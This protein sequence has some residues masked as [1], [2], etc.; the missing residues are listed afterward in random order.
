MAQELIQQWRLAV[1]RVQLD[2]SSAVPAVI[3]ELLTYAGREPRQL[4][5]SRHPI[6]AFGPID[7]AGP[8]H[9]LRVP[10]DLRD[11][12]AESLHTDLRGE[13]SLW[14]R[15]V[16]PYGY[17]GAVPWEQSLLDIV[18]VP[19]FRVPERLPVAT[20]P[21]RRWTVAIGVNA[22][23]DTD[24]A[25]GYVADLVASLEVNAGPDVEVDVF[26]DAGTVASLRARS[27]D[28]PAWAHL[29]EPGQAR[30]ASH[31]RVRRL[32]S[33]SSRVPDTPP[34]IDFT[35]PGRIWADW[36]A[37][38]LGGRAVRALH[39]VLDSVWDGDIPLLAVSADPSRPADTQECSFV[40]GDGVR[41]LADA[42]GA[43]TLSL[44]SPPECGSGTAMRMIADGIGQ[45]RPGA[46]I[47][48]EIEHDPR[49]AALARMHGLLSG[50]LEG[51][52]PRDRSLFAY[53]QPEQVQTS[54]L[55][56]WPQPPP[57]SADPSPPP[58]LEDPLP[59]S[60]LPSSYQLPGQDAV[61]S[62]YAEAGV[63]P[64]WVAASERYVGQQF[65][66]LARPPGSPDLAG[67][68]EAY[69][70]GAAEAL[71]EFRAIVAKHAK[72]R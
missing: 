46:T 71:A 66:D 61:G 54:M 16:P 15:L 11:D 10:D 37:T 60:S 47:H 67:Y 35:S 26:A 58:F 56:A 22:Q 7:E 4:W 9:D 32:M 21:G 27:W 34:P 45:Q 17:L 59:S 72:P 20:D 53:V 38:G 1:L 55:D 69:E 29:H 70:R 12:I 13:S 24:W 48:S 39:V 31:V 44:G 41:R 42:V 62:E 64:S 49:G 40:T 6:S 43:A 25:A 63:V 5:I 8:P 65:A 50:N 51:W 28:P 14:I 18:D 57:A 2:V 36:I 33:S 52:V 30:E 3:S 19:V 23:P 68:K